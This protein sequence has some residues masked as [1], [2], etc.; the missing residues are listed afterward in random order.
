MSVSSSALTPERAKY[1]FDLGLF[2]EA[3]FI[4]NALLDQAVSLLGESKINDADNIASELLQVGIKIKHLNYIKAICL[5]QNNKIQE[6]KSF[7][8]SE[9]KID[10]SN[11]EVQDLLRQVIESESSDINKP[12][13]LVGPVSN[14]ILIDAIDSEANKPESER[15]LYILIQPKEPNG[16][17]LGEF[18][19]QC[20][21]VIA[22]KN[23]WNFVKLLRGKMPEALEVYKLTSFN[24]LG[25]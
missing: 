13:L 2:S 5:I 16:D 24:R 17:Y 25:N 14:Q 3:E 1:F 15:N 22:Q 12:T 20:N 21:Q 18:E 8:E 4:A 10:P 7:L 6:S 19:K 9:L 11:A 23:A